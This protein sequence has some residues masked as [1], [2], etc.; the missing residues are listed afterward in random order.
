MVYQRGAGRQNL[1]RPAPLCKQKTK[2][3]A[4]RVL[5]K[6]T[7][8]SRSLIRTYEER[9]LCLGVLPLV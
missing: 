3:H 5:A 6:H 9:G 2:D 7:I 4:S 8:E 1:D